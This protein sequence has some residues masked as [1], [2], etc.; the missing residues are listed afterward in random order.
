MSADPQKIVAGVVRNRNDGRILL[1]L[2]PA[3]A[4]QG[5]TWEFPGGKVRPGESSRQALCRELSEEINICVRHAHRLVAVDHDY[6]DRKI[7]LELWVVDDWNGRLH[8]REGQVIEWVPAGELSSRRMPEANRAFIRLVSLPPLYLITP[9]RKSYDD[10]FLS[11]AENLIRSGVRLLQFRS[12]RS[13]FQEHAGAVRELAKLCNSYSGELLY[14]GTPEQAMQAGAH[15]VHLNSTLLMQYRARPL[16]P[17]YRVASSC[18][19]RR[20]IDEARRINADFCV[21]APVHETGTH[22]GLKGMGWRQFSSLSA[23][24]PIPVYALGGIR[25]QELAVAR[26]NGAH[27]VAMISAIWSAPDPVAALEEICAEA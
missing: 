5:R 18:H 27:G 20:E 1:S 6:P 8:A 24:S 15:G 10:G 21:L 17:E 2:R 25:P 12:T 4:H 14:N 9:D 11:L 23:S 16:S 13:S 26:L 3:R 22:P 19:N 7:T